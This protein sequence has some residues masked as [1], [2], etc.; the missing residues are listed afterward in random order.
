MNT[1]TVNKYGKRFKVQFSQLPGQTFG[2]W[3]F[4]ETVRDLT[5]SALLSPMTARDL[6][7]DAAVAGAATAEMVSA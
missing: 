4:P 5:V 3:G 7:M 1:V 2:P 6:V